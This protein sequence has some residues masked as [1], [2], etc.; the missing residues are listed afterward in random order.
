VQAGTSPYTYHWPDGQT[1]IEGTNLSSGSHLVTVT[2]KNGCKVITAVDIPSPEILEITLTELITPTCNESCNGK[3]KVLATG[4]TGNYDYQWT[5]FDG[6]ELINLCSG[7]YEV[8]A[9]DENKC[10]ATK[11]FM[12]TEPEPIEVAVQLLRSPTCFDGCDGGL[13]IKGSGGTG[14]LKY[15]WSTGESEPSIGNLCAGGFTVLLTDMNGCTKQQSF[16]LENPAA[17]LLDV[18]ESITLCAG[19]IYTLDPGPNWR[20]YF[21]KNNNGIISTAQTVNLTD[22]GMYLLETVSFDG[23]MARDTFLLQTSAD[24]LEAN[25]LMATEAMMADT[26]VLIEISWP[27]PDHVIWKLPQGLQML[28]SNADI[29]AG[30]FESPGFYEVSLTATL[31]ACK[32]E[33]TKGITILKGI[34]DMQEGRI[35]HEPFVKAFDLYPNPNQGIFDV[36]VELLEESAIILTVWSNLTGKKVAHMQ[37]S[38]QRSYL[39]HVELGG[40]SAGPYSLRLDY[41]HGT[42]YIRF[43]VR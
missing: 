8:K 29:I 10:M 39:K 3:I 17:P 38:G 41:E 35:G 12:I 34:E 33:I 21:W 16:N 9:S 25:F 13:Q 6:P 22:P 19:Q 36:A 40:L 31:G 14:D 23:C 30:T 2:D 20:N 43:I 26:V 37:E 28:E 11:S 27:L 1:M 24:L 32:D 15:S 42:R 5:N 4:G 18:G 7:M